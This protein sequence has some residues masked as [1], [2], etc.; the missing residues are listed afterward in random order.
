[1]SDSRTTGKRAAVLLSGGLDSAT[2]LGLAVAEH[3]REGVTGFTVSYGQRHGKETDCARSIA[4][5]Y[6][7]GVETIDLS[8]IFDGSKCSLLNG[9]GE[10]VP[11]GTYS[12]QI[13]ENGVSTYVPFRNGLMVAAIA[14]R[15]LSIDGEA[16]WVVYIGVHADDSAGEAYPDCSRRFIDTIDET[17]RIGTY[18]QVGVVAPFVDLHKSDVVATGLE[19]GVPYELTWSCYKGGERQ[20]GK[21][22]TCLDR[23]EAFRLNGAVDPVPYES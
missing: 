11:D 3:G 19:I 17:L 16:E 2:C 18:G 21:C 12:E 4:N 13:H 14:A 23:K 7:V 9:S 10:E 6:G 5:H 8:R 20:C 1:M 15:V 22:A